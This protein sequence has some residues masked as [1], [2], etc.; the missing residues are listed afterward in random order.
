[1]RL[2]VLKE[3]LEESAEHLQISQKE[4]GSGRHE[5]NNFPE[6][7]QALKNISEFKFL[8]DEMKQLNSMTIFHDKSSRVI[9]DSNEFNVFN[10]IVRSILIKII[11]VV[12]AIEEAIPEQN[13]N[14]V[15]IKLPNYN[16]LSE[17]HSFI[18][19]LDTIINQSLI[20]QYK[21]PVKL[22]NFDTG[23]N[24]LEIVFENKDSLIFFGGLVHYSA[25]LVKGHYLQSK[26][27]K[28][29]ITTLEADEQAKQLILTA[30]DNSVKAQ[31]QFYANALMNDFNISE[32]QHEFHSSL[33][34]NIEKFADLISKGTEVHTALNAPDE[35]QERFPSPTETQS[36]I[37]T[38]VKLLP[39]VQSDEE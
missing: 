30:L 31:A 14:S 27:M 12:E 18:K 6:L 19:D 33:T 35:A 26:Q 16:Q 32:S 23:S 11:S 37:E 13:E 9:V 7:Y 3:I 25:L 36:L 24:W 38:V 17:I 1:M 29:R 2:R 28:N 10:N 8:Q 39:D 5:V 21:G 15:S 34:H 4:L 22:Q 20:D